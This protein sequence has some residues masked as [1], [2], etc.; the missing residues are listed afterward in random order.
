M[1]TTPTVITVHD[2]GGTFLVTI[3]DDLGERL[4]VSIPTGRLAGYEEAR[5]RNLVEAID[6]VRAHVAK[7]RLRYPTAEVVGLDA[8][9][10]ADPEA[11]VRPAA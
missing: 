1:S 10:G 5:A 7:T 3:T 4:S 2:K 8:L 11:L 9:D 6:K